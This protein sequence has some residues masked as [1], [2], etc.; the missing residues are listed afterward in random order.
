MSR[1]TLRAGL[2]PLRP[3]E[4]QGL[5][6][7]AFGSSGGGASAVGR[8]LAFLP[9]EALELDLSDPEQR[10]FGDYEL[11]EQIGQGGMGVVYRAYQRSLDREVAVKLLAAG[12]WAAPA[13]I[14]RFRAEAQ[15]A[16]RLRHPNIV[17]VYE[18][19]NHAEL[20]FFSMGLVEGESLDWRLA[21]QGPLPGREAARLVRRVA[22]AVDYAHRLGIL[23]LDLKPANILVEAD[24]GEPQVADFGLAK[25]LDAT[26]RESGGD[27][28][29][30]PSYM[31]PEQARGDAHALGM[32]TDVYGLGAVLYELLC[33]RPPFLGA[34]A[35]D[36][37]R[38]VAEEALQPPS[39]FREGI[40]PDL[41]AI[42]L[43]CL[44]REPGDRYLS[45]GVLADD[46]G[47]YLDGHPVSARPLSQWQRSLRWARREP[48]VAGF[49]AFAVLALSLGLLVSGLQ[50]QRAETHAQQAEVNL[51]SA[52]AQVAQAA[53]A[54]GDAFRGMRALVENLAEMEAAGRA[55]HAALERHRIG[56]ILANAPQLV[57]QIRLPQGVSVSGLGLSPNGRHLA[58]ASF[59]NPPE[60]RKIS[61]IEWATGETL[62]ETVT[63]GLTDFLPY[64]SPHGPVQYTPDGSAVIANLLQGN[65]FP[66]PERN[67]G[68]LLDAASGQVR[69]PARLPENH[70]DFV[71]SDDGRIALQRSRTDATWRFAQNGQLFRVADWSPLGP[72]LAHEGAGG[73]FR[74]LVSPDGRAMLG[75]QDFL[76]VALVDPATLAPRW[77]FLLPGGARL[78]AWRFSH[79]GRWVALGSSEGQVWLLDAVS[80]TAEPLPSGLASTLRWLEFDAQD[81]LLAAS[82]EDGSVA[83]WDVAS[84]T[85]RL[86]PMKPGVMGSIVRVFGE[87]I[88]GISED[89]LWMLDLPPLSPFGREA[90]PGATRLRHRRSIWA[91][92]FDVLPQHRLLALGGSDGLIGLWRLQRPALLD[93]RAAPLPVAQADF[94]GRHVVAVDG[95]RVRLLDALSGAQRSPVWSH[96]QPLRLAE[97]A[98]GGRSLITLAGRTVRA[99]DVA[100]GAVRGEPLLLPQTPV[101]ADLASEAG[102]LLLATVEYRDERVGYRLHVLD[103]TSGPRLESSIW[104]DGLTA[105][106]TQFT[107]DPRGRYLLYHAMDDEAPGRARPR[108]HPLSAASATCGGPVLEPEVMVRSSA[109]SS[110]GD[111]AWT[112]ASTPQRRG[113]MLR[114][115]TRDC[116]VLQ[117]IPVQQGDGSNFLRTRGDGAVVSQLV[118]GRLALFFADGSRDVA[119]GLPIST[120]MR[121]FALSADGNL[122]ALASRNAVHVVDLVRG[123]RLSAPLAA[124]IPG[125]DA[126]AKLSFSP[127]ARSL[128][129]RTVQG[130]WLRWAIPAT[131]LPVDELLLLA[132]A[133]DPSGGDPEVD[134]ETFDAL[135]SLLRRQVDVSDPPA[136]EDWPEI[137]LP[138]IPGEAVDPRFLPLDLARLYNVPL[139]GPWPE[140]EH[141]AGDLP[142]LAP[143]LQ[144]FNGVDFR[145]EGGVQ[146]NGGGPATHFGAVLPETAELALPVGEF[147]RVHVLVFLHIPSRPG[148]PKRRAAR[149]VLVGEDGRQHALDLMT[150]T[151]AHTSGMPP[152]GSAGDDG[153][154]AWRG[155]GTA[156]VRDGVLSSTGLH[157]SFSVAALDLP[158]DAGALRSLRLGIGDGQMEAPLIYAVTLER[159]GHEK[160][161]GQ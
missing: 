143:G 2:P 44:A 97:L 94:D 125:N 135:R 158:A 90:V 51:W 86:V 110:D 72:R 149:I 126:I 141:A 96:P 159:A 38:R 116:R 133:L 102:R 108:L 60:L 9:L 145:L 150:P 88:Y 20:N 45:A 115:D 56:I 79:D 156:P 140:T 42:C 16:A 17:P 87:T 160:T 81:R 70:V 131:G 33:G 46:L 144:R 29:G 6:A 105:D 138:P 100:S 15:S 8:S 43:R 62:W 61:Q 103:A 68:I 107:L 35:R 69:Q 152:D 154:L 101:Y 34:T 53:M 63:E 13:F 55:D 122:A 22:E 31:A 71:Y 49:A 50:W 120:S 48:R 28:S 52:R 32:A 36:T 77:R 4:G 119:P 99:F 148:A 21:R 151:H 132:R 14:E 121:E 25:R 57:D 65:P 85:P 30:T 153:R 139:N 136:A 59:G 47:R 78:R 155:V 129:A 124:P 89:G 111:S 137:E 112:Y 24:S 134:S 1:E 67:D 98:D 18:I 10:D 66:A 74:W 75:S 12:P 114:W 58:V 123:E 73:G 11:L 19:G 142:T 82:A 127:D 40:S 109:V 106:N 157:A 26:L 91:A 117:R 23:H 92:G 130:R 161:R 128:L 7:L 41:D 39:A 27:V 147:T 3:G 95:S 118:S 5:G 104:V 84:R 80:G 93:V 76:S 146:L 113:V 54:E 37:L 83:A 64:L